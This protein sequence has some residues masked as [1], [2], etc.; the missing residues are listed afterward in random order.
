M[1]ARFDFDLV[2]GDSYPPGDGAK[3]TVTVSTG[4]DFDNLSAYSLADAE[5]EAV[6]LETKGAA[7]SLVDFATEILNQTTNTGEFTWRIPASETVDLS[8]GRC[9]WRLSVVWIGSDSRTTLLE[10]I[11]SVRH[12]H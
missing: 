8:P 11:V 2:I 3:F 1:P 6:L 4:P 12:A 5:I 10:G 7:V 9:P